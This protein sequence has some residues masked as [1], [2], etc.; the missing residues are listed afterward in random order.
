MEAITHDWRGQPVLNCADDPYDPPL[1]EEMNYFVST[2][3]KNLAIVNFD[4]LDNFKDAVNNDV[5]KGRQPRTC[6]VMAIDYQSKQENGVS[7]WETTFRI[8]VRPQTWDR[9]VMERGYRVK[10][11]NG[12]GGYIK[13][14]VVQQTDNGHVIPGPYLLDNLRNPP[15]LAAD[16]AALLTGATTTIPTGVDGTTGRG[17][18]LPVNPVNPADAA[19]RYSRWRIRPEK[20]FSLLGI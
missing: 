20:A 1:E 16:V 7:F 19:P 9:V 13:Q 14:Q 17:S 6:R 2:V 10:V 15:N 8:K 5:W 4:W 18:L 3:T 11:S 12:A